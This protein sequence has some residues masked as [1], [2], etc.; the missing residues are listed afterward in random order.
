MKKKLLSAVIMI[1]SILPCTVYAEGSTLMALSV[2]T[3]DSSNLYLWIG[4]TAASVIGFA[5]VLLLMNKR[6][7]K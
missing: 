5:A 1:I 4:L 6:N 3:G 7:K 2:Q